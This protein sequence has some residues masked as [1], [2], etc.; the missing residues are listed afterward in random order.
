MDRKGRRATHTTRIPTYRKKFLLH[1]AR[2]QSA[3]SKPKREKFTKTRA[4][5]GPWRLERTERA[6]G[7][8]ERPVRWP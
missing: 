1:D 3:Q 4:V 6:S 8:P 2:M 5:F 7:G